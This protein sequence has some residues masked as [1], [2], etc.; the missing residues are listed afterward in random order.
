L[1]TIKTLLRVVMLLPIAAYFAGLI[2]YLLL[3]AVFGDRHWTIG[4]LNVFGLYYFLPLV[5]AMPLVLLLRARVLSVAGLILSVIALF[6]AAPYYTPKAA[7]APNWQPLRVM[8]FNIWAGNTDTSGIERYIREIDADIVA[9]QEVTA[10]YARNGI[11]ALRDKYPY[12]FNVGYQWGNLILSRYP[13]LS[14]DKIGAAIG[15]VTH[16]EHQRVTFRFGSETIA[17]YNI[18]LPYPLVGDVRLRS[19]FRLIESFSRYD[20]RPR[21]ALM[22]QLLTRL[23]NE[24][25]PMLVMGD[26]NLSDHSPTYQVIASQLHD[27]WKEQGWGLGATWPNARPAGL[28]RYVPPLIRIDYIWHSDSFRVLDIRQGQ[29][30]TSDHLPIIATLELRRP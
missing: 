27:S 17:L 18:H 30:L 26:F 7:P 6:W 23:E 16:T 11:T 28:P 12:Q 29:P 3:R 13:F 1:K 25:Y 15:G 22:R 24:P 14:E 20:D 19:R 21:N 8:T 5:A 9:I 2:F 4:T 10:T